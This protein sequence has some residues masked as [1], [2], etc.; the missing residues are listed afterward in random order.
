MGVA[1]I[2]LNFLECVDF[3]RGR[4]FNGI[5]TL[6]NCNHDSV[7]FVVFFSEEES[8]CRSPRLKN[9]VSRFDGDLVLFY[10]SF[11]YGYEK[12]VTTSDDR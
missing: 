11:A 2:P 8:R 10:N 5:F 3:P 9:D 1:S 4:F 7:A 6:C 12:F